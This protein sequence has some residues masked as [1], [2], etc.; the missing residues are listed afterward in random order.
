M[1]NNDEA[2]C[3]SEVSQLVQRSQDQMPCSVWGRPKTLLWTSGKEA[4]LTD[5]RGAAAPNS[6]D[7]TFLR[8][9]PG[10]HQQRHISGPNTPAE[11]RKSSTS[12][13][14]RASLAASLCGTKAAPPHGGRCWTVKIPLCH[15]SWTHSALTWALAPL[16]SHFLHHNSLSNFS[17][18]M[19]ASPLHTE[20]ISHFHTLYSQFTTALW[21]LLLPRLVLL[22]SALP[23]IVDCCLSCCVVPEASFILFMTVFMTE[24]RKQHFFEPST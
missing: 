16:N 20:A 1:T 2:N 18:I 17:H 4:S 6:C 19:F 13:V 12:R 10:P 15:P 21:P 24:R 22:I 7:C 8:I 23:S 3:R 9:P 14:Y 5:H 11:E